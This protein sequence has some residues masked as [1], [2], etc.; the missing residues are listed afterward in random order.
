MSD[1]DRSQ[2]DSFA[3]WLADI[4]Q[5]CG[6]FDGEAIAP[7]CKASI[8]EYRQGALK[9][10]LVGASH[11]RLL[12]RPEE[13]ARASS[14]HY[15]AVFQLVGSARMVQGDA[16][17]TLEKGDIIFID[18]TQPS[19]FTYSDASRQLSLIL[20]YDQVGQTL[21]HRPV[22]GGYKIAAGVAAGGL[23]TQLLLATRA[24]GALSLLE[25]EAVLHSTLTLLRP[26]LL[27]RPEQE[28]PHERIFRKSL[29]L[30]DRHIREPGL[31]PDFV[32]RQ[33]GVSMRGL[34]RVF[35]KHGLVV[36]QYIKHRRLDLC[37]QALRQAA[38]RDK[39]AVVGYSWGFS[40]SSYF[41]TAFKARFGVSPSEYRKRYH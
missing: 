7:G 39:L 15:Y 30:I 24:Q 35:G 26:A 34:Y 37:A 14:H 29:D 2:R 9:M 32:A 25:S 21:A 12:R 19:E 6:A 20:P 27:A 33:I 4:N 17:E 16:R 41:T 1:L 5:I 22:E 31:S 40:N 10:S 3:G 38:S 8:E 23:A 13:V 28:D 11:L 18:N 36:A